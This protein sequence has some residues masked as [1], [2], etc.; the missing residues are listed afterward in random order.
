MIENG[1]VYE[2]ETCPACNGSGEGMHDGTKC[3]T[4]KGTGVEWVLVEEKDEMGM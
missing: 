4:C 3:K 2:Q 1:E